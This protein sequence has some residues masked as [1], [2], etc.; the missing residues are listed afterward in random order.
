MKLK[1]ISII[2]LIAAIPTAA[3]ANTTINGVGV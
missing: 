2:G 3:L 1:H